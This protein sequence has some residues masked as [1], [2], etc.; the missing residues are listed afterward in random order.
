[1]ISGVLSLR[2]GFLRQEVKEI[3]V[4]CKMGS[5]YMTGQT[6]QPIQTGQQVLCVADG[7]DCPVCIGCPIWPVCPVMF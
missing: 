4:R 2:G 6:G 5:V 1:M 7:T 3:T